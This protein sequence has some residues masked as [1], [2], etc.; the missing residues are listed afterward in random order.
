MTLD[1]AVKESYYAFEAAVIKQENTAHYDNIGLY[2]F[3]IPL[4]NDP[5]T[6]RFS[7]KLIAPILDYDIRYDTRLMETI[8]LYFEND[9]NTQKVSELIFQHKNTVLYR[10]RKIKDLLGPFASN[11]DFNEQM[12]IALKLHRINQLNM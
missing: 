9:C 2:Q 3:I 10:I 12:S 1:E 8:S 7:D 6:K 5:W 11:Q 4:L